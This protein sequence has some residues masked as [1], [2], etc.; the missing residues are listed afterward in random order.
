M[1]GYKGL[2]SREDNLVG[3]QDLKPSAAN[4]LEPR[5]KI[6]CFYCPMLPVFPTTIIFR[7]KIVFCVLT[8]DCTGWHYAVSSIMAAERNLNFWSPCYD[9]CLRIHLSNLIAVYYTAVSVS[10]KCAASNQRCRKNKVCGIFCCC[11]VRVQQAEVLSGNCGKQGLG[12]RYRHF[13]WTTYHNSSTG[14]KNM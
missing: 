5:S 10:I 14:W 13:L 8:T 4:H 2:R 11:A 6:G 12:K 7:F 3:R 9:H 1:W